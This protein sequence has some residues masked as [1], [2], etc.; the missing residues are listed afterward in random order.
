MFEIECVNVQVEIPFYHLHIRTFKIRT[1]IGPFQIYR[2]P[3]KAA[4]KGC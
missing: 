1:S 3:C 4:A 2:A